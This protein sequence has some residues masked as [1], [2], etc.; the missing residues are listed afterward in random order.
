MWVLSRAENLWEDEEL[1]GCE[2]GEV[3]CLVLVRQR[4]RTP[5]FIAVFG[6]SEILNA[7]CV[8]FIDSV[9]AV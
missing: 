8:K 9:A 5:G 1:S 4:A 3:K 6:P 2:R 7:E